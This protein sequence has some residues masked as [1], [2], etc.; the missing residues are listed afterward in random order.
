VSTRAPLPGMA[1]RPISASRHDLTVGEHQALAT[2]TRVTWDEL[3]AAARPLVLDGTVKRGNLAVL[4]QGYT[5]PL[6]YV[7]GPD[8]VLVA[9][10]RTHLSYGGWVRPGGDERPRITTPEERAGD[11][12]AAR[13][14][15]IRQRANDAAMDADARQMARRT[16]GAA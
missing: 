10:G 7:V 9:R 15:D 5:P 11:R 8:L 1:V 6:A 16:A 12:A 3:D 4:G 2:A 14:Y 13:E